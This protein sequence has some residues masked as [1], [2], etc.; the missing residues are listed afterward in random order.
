MKV[1]IVSYVKELIEGLFPKYGFELDN[2]NPE[3]VIALG[4]DGTFLFAE[5]KYPG[6]PK[7]LIRHK[8]GCNECYKHDFSE[9]FTKLS[10]GQY[11]II[12]ELKIE[13]IIGKKKLVA[14][15]EIN[16][17]YVPPR[18]LRFTVHVNGVQI[19][20]NMIGDGVVVSTP[21]G[22]TGYFFSIVRKSFIKGIGVAFNNT[23]DYVKPLYLDENAIV[24]VKILR[25]NGVVAADCN[26]SIISVK[27]GTEII[28]KSSLKKA[29]IL[30][31]KGMPKK[32]DRY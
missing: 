17:H 21:Y 15:N 26:D 16:V 18:A 7:L 28:I 5:Q 6:V 23:V 1:A 13:A 30:V 14:L 19:G 9:I 10:R 8:T 27:P 22:S 12:E 29:K 3:I 4:G 11:D 24:Q 32:I 2:K 20:N 31:L 25:E